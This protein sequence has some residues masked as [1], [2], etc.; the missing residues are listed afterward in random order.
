MYNPDYDFDYVVLNLQ[1]RIE[2]YMRSKCM[3]KDWDR[4][5][6]FFEE[7][8]DKWIKDKRYKGPRSAIVAQRYQRDEEDM[9]ISIYDYDD[10][11][12]MEDFFSDKFLPKDNVDGMIRAGNFINDFLEFHHD[13]NGDIHLVTIQGEGLF[14]GKHSPYIVKQ[15][16]RM[17][18]WFNTMIEGDIEYKWNYY[19]PPSD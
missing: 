2:D 12:P 15:I 3:P 8:Y 6:S 11:V 7:D 14:K 13:S 16:K 1:F 10:R 4:T 9:K 18:Y 19:G 17:E 5:K